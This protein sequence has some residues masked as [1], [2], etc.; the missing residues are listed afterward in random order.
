MPSIE[1]D[2]KT[3]ARFDELLSEQKV[4][5]NIIQGMGF[6]N[7]TP[8]QEAV[9]PDILQGR[10]VYAGAKTGSGKTVAFLAPIAELLY[11]GKIKKALVLSPVREL[12]LQIDEEA[13]KVLGPNQTDFV[14]MPLYGG[15]PLDQQ[16][17]ALK[18]HHPVLYI[19]TPGRMIDFISE[20]VLDLFDI[21]LCVLDEAD[22]MC[23]MGFSPQVTEILRT[24]PN[25]R[26]T[27]MFSATLPPEANDI[28]TQFLNNPVRIQVDPPDE[29]S[30]TITHRV[31]YCSSHEKKKKLE[32][33]I[34]SEE[35]S[36]LI[37]TRTRKSADRLYD[38]MRKSI[39]QLGVLH[40]GYTM[41][42]REKTIRQYREGKIKYLLATDVA[43][44][45]IDIERVNMV[46]NYELP[47]GADDYIHRSGRAGRA[48]RS[49]VSVSLVDPRNFAQAKLVKQLS[50]KMEI[51]F[52]GKAERSHSSSKNSRSR[53]TRKRDQGKKQTKSKFSHSRKPGT[54]H[55]SQNK[56]NKSQRHHTQ[57]QKA[58]TKKKE[59]THSSGKKILGKTTRLFK[60]MFKKSSRS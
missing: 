58:S 59:S 51:E 50:E 13:M 44:R 34:R 18:V 27:L 9:I 54:E 10:D 39:S 2:K 52:S 55:S 28:M 6:V 14:S 30:S 21:E 38:E 3:M 46:I 31:I 45:G 42:E 29:A 33:L 41:G 37:F 47:E 40:A 15:V 43:G 5:E 7:P 16:L 60:K 24:L 36:C 20:G 23:D 49:G 12:A 32:E 11:Q 26:Q 53:G 35:R 19:A 56:P 48:G 17:R 8:I 25:R 57:K 4:I 1:S 22:R